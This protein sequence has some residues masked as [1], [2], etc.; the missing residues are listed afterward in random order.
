MSDATASGSGHLLETI[1]RLDAA[2]ARA[3]DDAELH[4]RL[5][6]NLLQADR[7]DAAGRHLHRAAE[8]EP[9]TLRYV[10]TLARFLDRQR[11]HEKAAHRY[12]QVLQLQP[13]DPEVRW[14]LACVQRRAGHVDE[15]I[16][17]LQRLLL[18]QPDDIGVLMELG[19]AHW[20]RGDAEAATVQFVATLARQP[21][22]VYARSA[23]ASLHADR[24]QH[25]AGAARVALHMSRG[26][27]HAVLMPVFAQLQ[28][29]G[30]PVRL[31]SEPALLRQFR[32]DVIVSA[33]LQGRR[34]QELAPGAKSVYVRHGLT[35]KN[36]LR[37]AGASCDFLAGITSAHMARILERDHGLDPDRIWITGHVALDPLFRGTA[38]PLTF[39]LPARRPTIL[40]APTWNRW[41]SAVDLTR[42]R[43]VA[44]L[45]GVAAGAN[46]I[47][48]PHP[49][50]KRLR[51]DWFAAL[52]AAARDEPGVVLVDDPA[53]DVVPLLAAADV[54]VSDV[55][56]V[57]FSFL[58]LDRPVVLVTHPLRER[59]PGYEPGSIE[60]QWRDLG[61]E[62][63]D[64]NA[65]PAAVADALAHPHRD[66]AR[67][68]RYRDL[69]FGE[70]T[71]G[72]AAQRIA[73]RIG[74]LRN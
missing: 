27:H 2:V 59:D 11:L 15:S 34:L 61:T 53:A 72:R 3:P 73:E 30:H 58:A 14:R 55:S 51:P 26:F 25:D 5:G 35:G 68:A 45:R 8:L 16:A 7:T 29:A 19:T 42:D 62:V 66:A 13:D 18:D 37:G 74:Q 44:L 20:Q 36:H 65:L 47:L 69:L 54:L 67:R 28:E 63:T 46:V 48:K 6:V 40:F 21:D 10:L 50:T 9:G 1:R 22:N 52:R 23:L 38:P 64:I 41:L 31:T 49:H 60:W 32:P 57:M 4:F 43:T 71:D 33:D 12:R 39:P 17:A 70:F 24:G 56:S